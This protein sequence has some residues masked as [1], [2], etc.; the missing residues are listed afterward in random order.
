[1]SQDI[2]DQQRIGRDLWPQ[3]RSF[4]VK[5]AV[6]AKEGEHVHLSD[7]EAE[8]LARQETEREITQ[9]L[10]F[11]ELTDPSQTRPTPKPQVNYV[12]INL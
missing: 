10:R 8:T 3:H 9:R 1:M 7:G 4:L 12:D 11:Y 6:E 2:T 5:L